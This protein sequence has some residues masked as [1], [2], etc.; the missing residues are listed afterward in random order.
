MLIYSYLGLFP[1]LKPSIWPIVTHLPSR[2]MLNVSLV[3]RGSLYKAMGIRTLGK[4]VE[5][6]MDGRQ[7]RWLRMIYCMNEDKEFSNMEWKYYFVNIIGLF[8][9][10]FGGLPSAKSHWK[11]CEKKM[12]LWLLTSNSY[13]LGWAGLSNILWIF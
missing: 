1:N 4:K 13:F 11:I 12:L 7:P 3:T 5:E 9:I 10:A 6:T 8:E 2:P